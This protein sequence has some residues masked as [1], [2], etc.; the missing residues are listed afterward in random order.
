MLTYKD[1]L[2]A[3]DSAVCIV[4]KDL[5]IIDCNYSMHVLTGFDVK[6]ITGENL[7]SITCDD[8]LR[9]NLISS[10]E[11]CSGECLIKTVYQIPILAKYKAGLVRD[12]T[13]TE[14]VYVISFQESDEL[15]K[16]GYARKEKAIKVLLESFINN[17]IE[18]EYI[19]RNFVKA[20]D[21]NAHIF[22][23]DQGYEN[24]GLISQRALAYAQIARS[25]KTVIFYNDESL[26]FFPIYYQDEIYS[27]ICIKFLTPQLYDNED[28]MII[29]LAGK[30]LGAYIR[31]YSNKEINS[32]VFRT[33][34]DNI[35]QPV[36]IV[37]K[38]GKITETNNAV[39][40][41]Y[42]YSVVD[43]IGKSFLDLLPAD[44]YDSYEHKFNRIINGETIYKEEMA[45]VRSD[46]SLISLA[47]TGIPI[48]SSDRKNTG[49]I[50]I[51]QDIDEQRKLQDKIMQWEK[52]SVLG[53]LL[54]S[55]ANELNNSLTTVIGNA[56]RLMQRDFFTDIEN[57]AG[58]I[59]KSSIRCG[60]V[61]NGLLDISRDDD[62]RKAYSNLNGIIGAAL[63]LKQYQLKA[64]NINVSVILDEH[65]VN[66]A[67][68]LHDVERLFLHI[69]DYAERR[70]L[71]YGEGG[72]LVIETCKMDG[73]VC[74]Q[75]SDTGTCIIA[76]EIN[77]L[78]NQPSLSYITNDEIGIELIAACQ[79]LQR[80]GGKI[81]VESQIGKPNII[82]IEIPI[83][84]EQLVTN[85]DNNEDILFPV[86][87]LGKKV[88]LVDDEPDIIDL[89]THFLKQMGF[90]VDVAEDGNSALE[91][92]GKNHYDLIIS[93]LKMP[94]GFTG[95]KLHKFIKY[96]DPDLAQ[97]MIFMTGDM[98]N[99]ETQ[100]FLASTGNPYLEKPFL[101]E[102][103][104]KIINNMLS[105]VESKAGD[106]VS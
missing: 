62:P 4:N 75:F 50:F 60:S 1:L 49:V 99:H 97:R 58:K 29:D 73:Y 78:L 44:S 69:I 61:V 70:M 52:L 39:R 48:N 91:K 64:N 103:L 24:N 93:D 83:S 56:Q 65:T 76:D 84:E 105:T 7:S 51:M 59:Y 41:I 28:I 15:K 53:E 5:K 71:A 87:K 38:N 74:V 88:M 36:I 67:A 10:Y 82:R 20:Y 68:D 3:S 102:S 96:K 21:E 34:F 90:I 95:D 30:V 89:L 31:T 23:L 77:Y 106:L 40:Y 47:V 18:P 17:N 2:F 33:I 26:C 85:F 46:M 80:I 86:P 55:A 94:Y 27:V 72:N 6:S 25:K 14:D 8:E 100:K 101:P 22:L 45:H 12:Q 16:N 13:T 79:I 43:M 66:V 42:G 81:Y 11:L 35:D 37:D 57:I 19:I 54:Y 104:M 63:D 32:S 98:I 9:Q 92:I